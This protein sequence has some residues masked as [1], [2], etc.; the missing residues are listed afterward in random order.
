MPPE[1]PSTARV[2]PVRVI[3]VWMKRVRMP[4]TSSALIE[5][6]MF[7]LGMADP[8]KFFLQHVHAFVP[9]QRQADARAL[10][11]RQ[12]ELRQGQA[13]FVGGRLGDQL[14]VRVEDGGGAPEIQPVLESDA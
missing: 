11:L 6:S 8:F 9:E 7:I 1:R 3:S 2:R 4:S 14:P 13:F 5:R 10:Q 12:V